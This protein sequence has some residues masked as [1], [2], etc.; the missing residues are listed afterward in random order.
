[1]QA[2]EFT[3]FISALLGAAAFF[4]INAVL[5]ATLGRTAH[6]SALPARSLIGDARGF[7]TSLV[8]LAP[9]GWL[10]AQMYTVA[11]WATLLFALPLYTTRL[12]YHHFIEMREMFTQTIG[13]LAEAVDK[14]DPF[15]SKHSLAGQGDRGRH[16]AGDAPVSEA[17]LEA[18]EWGGLLHD[19]G[20][21]GV[22]D[23]VLLKQERLTREERMIMNAHPVLGA[24][25]I[26]PVTRLAPELPI[27][28]HH[29]E[30]YNGSG[31][32]DRLIGDEIPHARADPPRRRRVRG[33]DRP[34]AVPH[35]AAHR[36]AG[37]GR[38]AQVRRHPVRSRGRRRVRPDDRGSRASSDPGR[39]VQPRPIPLIS[40]HANRRGH[41][42]PRRIGPA[43][44]E[45]TGRPQTLVLDGGRDARRGPSRSR[46]RLAADADIAAVAHARIAT[47]LI[48][49]I[50]AR[51]PPRPLLGG[52]LEQLADIRLRSCR[53][54]SS[55]SSSGSATE[56][57]LVIR[58]RP[59]R[60]APA[61]AV[62]RSRTGCCCH[63]LW[64]NRDYP[65]LALAFVGILCNAIA[66]MVNGGYMPVWL[67]SLEA[68]GFTGRARHSAL[69]IPLPATLDAEF[70]LRLGPLGD[71]I[72]IPIPLLQN[73]ASIGDLFLTAGLAFFLFATVLRSP[74]DA[75]TTR[76]RPTLDGPGRATRL[77]RRATRP[78]PPGVAA[79]RDGAATA[80][81]AAP[82]APGSSAGGPSRG[83]PRRA[84]RPL[85]GPRGGV[86]PRAPA[87][88]GGRVGLAAS[89]VGRRLAMATH[90]GGHCRRSPSRAAIDASS[91][92]AAT[93][94]SGSRSTARSRRCGRP[95]DQPVRRP[96]PPDRA[97]AFVFEID[98]LAARGRRSSFLAATLPNL[99]F[100]PDRR[101]P[102]R[103]LGPEA[104]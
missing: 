15:T 12:A 87:V 20:K 56:A 77:R 22:P 52:R 81:L 84:G 23:N 25:I 7:A 46:P 47:M 24:Q 68:A 80:S 78:R 73:V 90:A 21:I 83:R 39:T 94:T 51:A 57:S 102:R 28:R 65:G 8:A 19:V 40:Q 86:G 29:H 97:V 26:A 11:W 3:S 93:R 4:L 10:M 92:S 76:R 67:P 69:H 98:R 71:I 45:L 35:D 30:W 41:G 54:C 32:P 1:M 17:E 34:A 64:Q 96:G 5:T 18:L 95:A 103:S 55:A 42:R 99:L 58:R 6:G 61:A 50:A 66:I 101:A 48:G 43:A 104:R 53:C 62:R 27:I 14:R 91:A 36:R 2:G 100:S 89:R 9:L 33:D 37:A 49:G 31:Y 82:A 63:A 79:P 85:A 75:A 70:L 38:A 59:R 74:D 13:A 16:R 60:R 44:S 88:L 72:P